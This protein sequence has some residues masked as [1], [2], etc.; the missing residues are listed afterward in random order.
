LG[1]WTYL[2]NIKWVL[3]PAQAH[4]FNGSAEAGVK[5]FK[6]HFLR[7]YGKHSYTFLELHCILTEI[8]DLINPRPLYYSTEKEEVITP[9]MLPTQKRGT[10]VNKNEGKINSEKK[11]NYN[12]YFKESEQFW[13]LW[14][15]NYLDSLNGRAKWT[16]E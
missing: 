16:R 15:V 12:Y 2:H 8:E 9:F 13:H 1:K 10:E 11:L 6:R 5:L 3:I 7:A 14:M 4:H